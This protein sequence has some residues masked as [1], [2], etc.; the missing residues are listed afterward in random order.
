MPKKNQLLIEFLKKRNIQKDIID[1]VIHTKRYKKLFEDFRGIY[2]IA[3]LLEK[4]ENPKNFLKIFSRYHQNLALLEYNNQILN[5]KILV[6]EKNK[7]LDPIH[8]Q[9]YF[10]FNLPKKSKGILIELKNLPHW[11][12]SSFYNKN[13]KKV[14]QF[15]YALLQNKKLLESLTKEEL[16]KFYFYLGE[17][18]FYQYIGYRC[19]HQYKILYRKTNNKIFLR[20]IGWVLFL[21]GH[22]SYAK[23]HLSEFIK[24]AKENPF[25]KKDI[26]K[27]ETI[28][29]FIDL[30][31]K[32]KTSTE[33]KY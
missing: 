8:N 32:L 29:K 2:I 26:K 19:L 31:K 1:M 25:W 13:Y 4:G 7:L 12:R 24:Y 18:I 14:I 9:Y 5:H 20:Y 11:I 6:L 27:L 16:T 28:L 3:K 17:S 23:Y 30:E 21:H 10:D 33:M 15:G 22:Y